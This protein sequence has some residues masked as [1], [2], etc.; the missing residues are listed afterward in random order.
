MDDITSKIRAQAQ[1]IAD[2]VY[3]AE[4]DSEKS[5]VFFEKIRESDIPFLPCDLRDDAEQ[6]FL[7]AFEA[8]FVLGRAN[9]PLAVGLTMHLYNLAGLATLPVPWA[10]EFERR[11]KVM[12]DGVKRYKSLLA[13]SSFGEN[14]RSK[15]A[16]NRNVT[17]SLTETGEYLCNGRKNFQ[18]MA[19]KA[20]LLLFSGYLPDGVMGMFY[21]PLKGVDA[22]KPGP[23][24]FSGAMSLTDTRPLQFENLLIKRRQM[25]SVE[26]D[27]T[28]HVSFYSTA[29]FEALVSAAYLGGASR[30][31]E[32][33][34]SFARSVH[35]FGEEP[36]SELDG[37]I[38]EAG[39]LSIKLRTS[40]ALS[41]AFGACVGNYCRSLQAK[42]DPE[43]LDGMSNDLMDSA[44]A[45][46]YTGTRNA[47]D[48][49]NGART[50]IGTRS[51][52]SGSPIHQLTEQICF[53]P[54]H[55]TIS[56]RYERSMGRE[57]LVEEP[58]YGWFPWAMG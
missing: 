9:V 27:L 32:E 19:T 54:L 42:A 15:E 17:V 30:A 24:L 16:A 35:P 53:G 13:I 21:T 18:S 12:V 8:L 28:D 55:P 5:D 3:L 37:F 23:S 46:K 20:D 47:Q 45:L 33:V 57:M 44:S 34:R 6:V 52:A 10:P 4:T 56:A 43:I 1:E 40:L 50:L 26:E 2:L 58:Y 31:I 7:R 22:I 49:V 48:V 25:L 51:M 36:L 38:V 11:R 39:R 41:R 29:W 14:I